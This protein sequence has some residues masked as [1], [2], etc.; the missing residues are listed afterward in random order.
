MVGSVPSLAPASPLRAAL[1]ER[2]QDSWLWE[3]HQERSPRWVAPRFPPWPSSAPAPAAFWAWSSRVPRCH[4]SIWGTKISTGHGK[5][6][7]QIHLTPV[8]IP[9][10]VHFFMSQAPRASSILVLTLIVTI[11]V[12]LCSVKKIVIGWESLWASILIQLSLRRFF[13]L[14]WISLTL[15]FNH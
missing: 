6:L 11:L 1:G 10:R 14:V 5:D 12:L 9:C 4:F 2:L 13:E 3:C 8:L 15:V 7:L